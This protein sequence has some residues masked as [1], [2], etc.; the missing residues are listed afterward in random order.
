MAAL[1]EEE[2][3]R[4]QIR[5]VQADPFSE[6]GVEA[7]LREANSLQARKL[8][9]A[10]RREQGLPLLEEEQPEDEDQAEAEKEN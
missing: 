6:E 4:E 3:E 1:G 2:E 9:K 7:W 8:D 5:H 10:S